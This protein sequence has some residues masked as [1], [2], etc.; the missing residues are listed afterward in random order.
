MLGG[1]CS[2]CTLRM[3]Y[4]V[5]GGMTC[6]LEIIYQGRS[7]QGIT[8]RSC[9]NIPISPEFP[10]LVP[11]EKNTFVVCLYQGIKKSFI[12]DDSKREASSE[13]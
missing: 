13:A 3:L 2:C 10:Q 12:E 4:G 7:V 8:L 6:L 9:Q 5:S 11:G 1:L